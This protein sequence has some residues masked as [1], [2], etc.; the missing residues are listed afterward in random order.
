MSQWVCFETKERFIKE[1]G[2]LAVFFD[3]LQDTST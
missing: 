1:L 3:H 2:S